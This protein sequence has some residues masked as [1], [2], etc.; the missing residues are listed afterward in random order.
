MGSAYCY[1]QPYP[2]R[3]RPC[4][5]AGLSF[6]MLFLFVGSL[7][8]DGASVVYRDP[9]SAWLKLN[10]G[11]DRKFVL[12]GP[13]GFVQE[14][15]GP[16]TDFFTHVE[17]L[18]PGD[19][20]TPT[21]YSI[22]HYQYVASAW[23]P[24]GYYE[25]FSLD[26]RWVGTLVADEL[27]VGTPTST[28]SNSD[29]DVTIPN[30]RTLEFRGYQVGTLAT[31]G[32]NIDIEVSGKFRLHNCRIEDLTVDRGTVNVESS[33]L[34][35]LHAYGGTLNLTD[36]E[37]LYTTIHGHFG[38]TWRGNLF[39]DAL[40]YQFWDGSGT[41]PNIEVNSFVARTAIKDERSSGFGQ[42]VLGSNY[43][44]DKRGPRYQG[45]SGA[46]PLFGSQGG[47]IT[48]SHP[49]TFVID[50]PRE[51]RCDNVFDRQTFPRI[52]VA[53]SSLCGVTSKFGNYSDLPFGKSAM[54][55]VLVTCDEITLSDV[56][57]WVEME[58]PGGETV[59]LDPE[60]PVT[61]RRDIN[62][63]GVTRLH[64]ARDML[65][66]HLP[67]HDESLVTLRLMRDTTGVSGYEGTGEVQQISLTTA[68]YESPL[69]EP[70]RM[71]IVPVS[72]TISGVQAYPPPAPQAFCT[73]LRE[74][75]ELLLGLRAE[76]ISIEVAP[77][78]VYPRSL[79]SQT[80][81]LS[82]IAG[83]LWLRQRWNQW[84]NTKAAPHFMVALMPPGAL[85]DQIAGASMPVARQVLF[86][87]AA[88][89]RAALHELGHYF[90]LYLDTE[91]YDLYPPDGMRIMGQ[92]TYNAKAGSV[93]HYPS[94]GDP[95][96]DDVAMLLD[97]M[98]AGLPNTWIDASTY[99]DFYRG[100]RNNLAQSAPLMDDS[101]APM[102]DATDY[103]VVLS[104]NYTKNQSD[105]AE[106]VPGTLRVMPTDRMPEH[107]ESAP[108][109]TRAMGYATLQLQCYGSGGWVIGYESVNMINASYSDNALNGAGTWW[110]TANV[111]IG[112]TRIEVKDFASGEFI[113][114]LHPAAGPQPLLEGPAPNATI[115]E[116]IQ[117]AWTQGNGMTELLTGQPPQQALLYRQQGDSQWSV[118]FVGDSPREIELATDFL[119]KETATNFRMVLSDGF[120]SYSLDAT[121]L[122][123][124]N[125]APVI[126]IT[127]P[128]N[129]QSAVDGTSWTLS[130]L[131]T[132]PDGD[133]LADVQWTSSID[134]WLG[135]GQELQGI[136][137]TEGTHVL[138]CSAT[139]NQGA[140]STSSVN[141]QVRASGGPDLRMDYNDFRL[142]FEER[143]VTG[144]SWSPL[145]QPVTFALRLRG[146]GATCSSATLQLYMTPPGGTESSYCTWYRS[147]LTPLADE[148]LTTSCTLTQPGTYQFRAQVTALEQT[149]PEP[150]NNTHTW[151]LGTRDGGVL[152]AVPNNIDFGRFVSTN[153]S[154]TRQITL[155]NTGN[156]PLW[157][158]AFETKGDPGFTCVSTHT[159]PFAIAPG[160]TSQ[161]TVT[162][163][164]QS[165]EIQY[166]RS[167]LYVY[168]GAA[169]SPTRCVPL[170]SEHSLIPTSIQNWNLWQ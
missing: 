22:T 46:C 72:L 96:L 83:N 160:N 67:A 150:T 21:P 15:V 147:R 168:T 135:S 14:W 73:E 102:S 106:I 82:T 33:Y 155:T 20:T 94:D 57:F 164:P 127:E 151:H 54:W 2:T 89:P 129:A 64:A 76:D 9:D 113:A 26:G 93:R 27:Y 43:W 105:M 157:I 40:E 121:G 3:C 52:W 115:E 170:R 36:N 100:L 119:A 107:A 130:A 166:Y 120:R 143:Q 125:R 8:G 145:N 55:S 18:E 149:D 35:S 90:G 60:Q 74:Q 30:L 162:F 108:L 53:F 136:V 111:P 116:P 103:G 28:L 77:P 48:T 104:G 161:I 141:V 85:G 109:S 37:V 68:Q 148:W 95:A 88:K 169:E 32:Y 56:D 44:G 132:E 51:L 137:L 4:V 70:L 66:F 45:A 10:L 128:K 58:K 134:G 17:G 159:P 156:D 91:Q 158:N 24:T 131:V 118:A 117:F 65:N 13:S 29:L 39:V 152:N 7:F 126:K 80:L 142:I 140:N 139:D 71:R 47:L 122:K 133:S 69:A 63:L 167:W 154:M 49:E 165:E 163:T 62:Q 98:G 86:C 50:K 78:L 75:M 23:N 110:I 6:A 97:V 87:D 5:I 61:L 84:F 16:R 99:D 146:G 79:V 153:A 42:I 59:R 41:Y 144:A 11:T 25:S 92:T 138:E 31:N 1:A 81:E 38:G 124:P 34:L 123:V 101:F 12:T 112:T 19:A 114:S